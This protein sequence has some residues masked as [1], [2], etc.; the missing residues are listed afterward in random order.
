GKEVVG[1]GNYIDQ[2]HLGL[3]QIQAL[4]NHNLIGFG[5][6]LII[7]LLLVIGLGAR[8][9]AKLRAKLKGARRNSRKIY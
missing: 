5:W 8:I 3:A 1:V 7:V 6:Q 4:G 9:M 2:T